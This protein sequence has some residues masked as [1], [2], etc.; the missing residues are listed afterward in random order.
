MHSGL[1]F[2]SLGDDVQ[3][4][5]VGEKRMVG[6]N[7]GAIALFLPHSQLPSSSHDTMGHL[8]TLRI[9]GMG[10]RHM[11]I[12]E[13]KIGNSSPR[14]R[15]LNVR[16]P[17]VVSRPGFEFDVKPGHFGKLHRRWRQNQNPEGGRTTPSFLPFHT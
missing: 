14:R 13:S 15:G 2:F 4:G 16:P 1:Y 17:R 3:I 8:P 11:D 9:P 12:L 6:L 5:G 7:S 10:N